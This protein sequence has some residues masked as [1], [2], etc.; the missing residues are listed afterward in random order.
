MLGEANRNITHV[1]PR[2]ALEDGLN[3]DTRLAAGNQKGGTKFGP[4]VML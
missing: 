1:L 2:P 4:V 3:Y